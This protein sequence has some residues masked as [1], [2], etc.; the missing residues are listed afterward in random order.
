MVGVRSKFARIAGA[1]SPEVA[2]V[3]ALGIQRGADQFHFIETLIP[4]QTLNISE[5]TTYTWQ[6]LSFLT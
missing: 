3:S 4:F 2:L 6:P 1:D 5:I